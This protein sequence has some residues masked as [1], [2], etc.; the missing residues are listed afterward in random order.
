MATCLAA[1]ILGSWFSSEVKKT[2]LK[3]EPAYKA[4]LTLPGILICLLVIFLPI[5]AWLLKQ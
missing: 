5:F 4:Y 1:G 3:G 2:K